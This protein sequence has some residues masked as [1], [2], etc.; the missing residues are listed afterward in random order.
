[1]TTTSR[2]RTKALPIMNASTPTCQTCAVPSKRTN[3]SC[4][5]VVEQPVRGRRRQAHDL[6]DV[7]QRHAVAALGQRA[8]ER[9]GAGDGLD[10]AGRCPCAASARG[11]LRVAVFIRSQSPPT[12]TTVAADP[13]IA[14]GAQAYFS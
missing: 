6:G 7:G 11:S 10:L 14:R 2:V 3:R 1:M 12:V 8:Q 9:Q 5:R 13:I 4:C